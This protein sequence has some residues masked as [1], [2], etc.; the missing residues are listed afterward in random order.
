MDRN[1]WKINLKDIVDRQ[2]NKFKQV[3]IDHGKIKKSAKVLTRSSLKAHVPFLL[4]YLK[5]HD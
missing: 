1:A 5:V 2:F 3:L 4:E